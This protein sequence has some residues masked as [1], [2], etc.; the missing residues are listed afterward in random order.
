ML[1]EVPTLFLVAFSLL[2]VYKNSLDFL[3]ALGGII[4]FGITL[5]VAT[6][7]YKRARDS[8]SAR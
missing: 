3:I 5:F 8:G 4:L 1:N 6:K 7:A 2:A